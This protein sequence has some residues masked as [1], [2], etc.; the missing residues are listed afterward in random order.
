MYVR[1]VFQRQ[2]TRQVHVHVCEEEWS[3][4]VEEDPIDSGGVGGTIYEVAGFAWGWE[5]DFLFS[6]VCTCS[7]VFVCVSSDCGE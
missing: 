1:E 6:L 2:A 7:F 3:F 4:R 5:H